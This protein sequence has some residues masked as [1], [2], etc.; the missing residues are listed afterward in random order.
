M[1]RPKSERLYAPVGPFVEAI[2]AWLRYQTQ[3]ANGNLTRQAGKGPDSMPTIAGIGV[4][5]EMAGTSTRTINDY[6][7]GNVRHIELSR[8]DKLANALDIPLPCL[9]DDFRPINEWPAETE[10]ENVA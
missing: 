6:R 1:P 4:L 5:A 8:A 10:L 2:D 9:A 3:L 7:H